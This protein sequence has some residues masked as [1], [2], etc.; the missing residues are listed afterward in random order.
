MLNSKFP[1]PIVS[2]PPHLAWGVIGRLTFLPCF[3]LGPADNTRWPH[4]TGRGN[5]G[6]T[7]SRPSKKSPPS[8][9][10]TRGLA[11]AGSFCPLQGHQQGSP[12]DPEAPDKPSRLTPHH[13]ASGNETAIETTAHKS[14]PGPELNLKRVTECLLKSKIS[15]GSRAS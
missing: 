6:T 5:P 9:G 4:S 10:S 11:W 13:K 7:S 12:G 3:L 8:P 14:N 15:V 1:G 2:Q